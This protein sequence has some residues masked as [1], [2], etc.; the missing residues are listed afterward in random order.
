MDN[1]TGHFGWE[2]GTYKRSPLIVN[3]VHKFTGAG[4][5]QVS[6]I[7]KILKEIKGN[8]DHTKTEGK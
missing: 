8:Y 3:N 4:V 2:H 6:W 5:Q 7:Q 1:D